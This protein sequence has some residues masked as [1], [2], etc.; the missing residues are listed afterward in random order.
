MFEQ[1]IVT[2]THKRVDNGTMG[3]HDY[4]T[5]Y[6]D[7]DKFV[8]RVTVRASKLAKDYDVTVQYPSENTAI[9]IYKDHHE[10]IST[11]IINNNA[12]PTMA[13][14]GK[15]VCKK[16]TLV[17]KCTECEMTQNLKAEK[18]LCRDAYER[19]LND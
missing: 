3:F 14:L 18:K 5:K 12:I 7:F 17:A 13:Q 11:T 6:E 1:E 9:I 4:E 19:Y 10:G 16:C 2:R 15:A 8:H